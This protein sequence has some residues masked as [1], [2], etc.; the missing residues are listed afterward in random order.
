MQYVLLIHQGTTPLPGTPAWEA[1]APQ[2][3]QQIFADYG[4]LNDDP[5]VTAG[6]PLGSAERAAVVRVV[7]GDL[8]RV[9]GPLRPDPVAGWAVV[10]VESA[11]EAAQIAA[12]IPAAR[13]GGAIESRP[14]ETYW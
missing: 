12:T 1:L 14:V 7:E 6:L 8:H 2:A 13:L 9:D 10:E 5:R 3:Q 4:R 11:E